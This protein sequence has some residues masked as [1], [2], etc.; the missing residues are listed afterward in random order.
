MSKRRKRR[1]IIKPAYWETLEYRLTEIL[2]RHVGERGHDE[3]AEDVL[4][5]IIGERDRAFKAIAID[6]LAKLP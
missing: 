2:S 5:R 4:S 1:K 3:G 6:R